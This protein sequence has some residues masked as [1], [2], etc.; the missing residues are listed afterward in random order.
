[1]AKKRI[2][3]LVAAYISL[4]LCAFIF[5]LYA[6]RPNWATAFTIFPAWLWMVLWLFSLPALRQKVFYV[7][8]IAWAL[9]AVFQVEEWQSLL[10]TLKPIEE[11]RQNIRVTTINASSDID[12]LKDAL[13]DKPDVVLLQE[14]PNPQDVENL[15]R[16]TN[17]YTCLYGFDTSIIVRGQ[18]Q[19][20]DERVYYKAATAIIDGKEYHIVSVRLLTSNP[21]IDLWDSACWNTQAHMRKSQLEQLQVIVDAIPNGKTLIV[22]GDFNVPQRDKVFSLLKP[23]MN[24]SFSSGGR[25]WCN[26][27]LVQVPMLRIDQI[28]TSGDL[29]CYNSYARKAV[30][31][32]HKLYTAQFQ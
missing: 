7:T 30:D 5:T 3:A 27:I 12:A 4:S 17:G 23:I 24:D 32:D 13:T 28:W 9:F 16:E 18:L 31:T 20:L 1:M 2:A 29:H 14:S 22:G 8:T 25:G 15:I 26:T 21:R 19:L 11:V 10:R 6:L